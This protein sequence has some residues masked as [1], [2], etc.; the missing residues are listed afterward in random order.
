MI[1]Q[2]II[3]SRAS[4]KASNAFAARIDIDCCLSIDTICEGSSLRHHP[5][6]KRKQNVEPTFLSG[7]M[8]ILS[9]IVAKEFE[10]NQRPNDTTP[11]YS[12]PIPQAG[13]PLEF[14]L[15]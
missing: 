2:Q 11:G 9:H 6:T 12:T 4:T 3:S 5:L 14:R 13:L 8:A 1:F 10:K 7:I 15:V